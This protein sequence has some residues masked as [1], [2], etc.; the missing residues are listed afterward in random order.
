MP[1]KEKCYAV[2]HGDK[3]ICMG[4]SQECANFMGYANRSTIR[5]MASKSYQERITRF[6]NTSDCLIAIVVE[7][8]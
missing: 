8:E 2:Y 5:Y 1:Q 6:K 4:S 3:F 7:D